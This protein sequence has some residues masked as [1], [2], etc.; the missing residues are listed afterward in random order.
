[1][2]ICFVSP[3]QFLAT[4]GGIDRVS[5]NLIHKFLERGYSVVCCFFEP[6]NEPIN[7]LGRQYLLPEK[8]IITSEGNVLELQR[9]IA[10]NNI[11]IIF[12]QSFKSDTMNLCYRAKR[13]SSAKIITTIHFDPAWHIK[14]VKDGLKEPYYM[15][16]TMQKRVLL[17]IYRSLKYPLT[18]HLRRRMLRDLYQSV[19]AFSDAVVL[20]SSNFTESYK[21]ISKLTELSKLYSITNPIP[22]SSYSE[23]P[24]KIDQILYVGRMGFGAKR[25]DR[26]LEIWKIAS[27]QLPTYRLKIVGEGDWLERYKEI[28]IMMNIERVEFVGRQD[29]YPFYR[30]S[31]LLC[32]TSTAEGFGMILAEAQSNYCVPFAFDTFES[33]HDIIED[34]VNGVLV[35]PFSSKEYERKLR[36]LMDDENLRER[37]MNNCL[38]KDY[39]Q[40][41][42]K[43]VAKQWIEL[44]DKLK[45]E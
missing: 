26:L 28:S 20:L 32:L 16:C 8:D 43:N 17:T 13:G 31:K 38:T 44:F 27:K 1:M 7:D 21:N 36:Q 18:C 24:D 9:I 39:S 40:F 6:K 34:G 42:V 22:I 14:G 35:T 4:T 3:C 15:R 10:E 37:M 30:E 11:D 33:V 23:K 41:D 29:S 2:N 19:D 5:V 25:I 45:F 12:N